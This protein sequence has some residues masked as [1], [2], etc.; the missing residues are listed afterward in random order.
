[1]LEIQSAKDL[2]D[3]VSFRNEDKISTTAQIVMIFTNGRIRE[4][5]C[6]VRKSKPH[7]KSVKLQVLLCFLPH[8][9][10]QHNASSRLFDFERRSPCNVDKANKNVQV[11]ACAFRNMHHNNPSSEVACPKRGLGCCSAS[12]RQLESKKH[13]VNP[14]TNWI[15]LFLQ[16]FWRRKRNM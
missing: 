8:Q 6:H 11:V 5:G 4:R 16:S 12:F 2:S 7:L 9:T 15:S 10:Q 1:M 3:F 13:G 14:A